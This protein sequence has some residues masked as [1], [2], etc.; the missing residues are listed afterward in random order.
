VGPSALHLPAA[1]V[2]AASDQRT[3]AR[4]RP[5]DRRD[6]HMDGAG[7]LAWPARRLP[8]ASPLAQR[9]S[10]RVLVEL[11]A[12]GPADLPVDGVVVLEHEERAAESES[13]ER[14]LRERRSVCPGEHTFA[15]YVRL[16][17]ATTRTR[18]RCRSGDRVWL[19]KAKLARHPLQ[20][21]LHRGPPR[22]SK[23]DGIPPSSPGRQG[24]RLRA[25]TSLLRWLLRLPSSG[26]P[27]PCGSDG[28]VYSSWR[29]SSSTAASPSRAR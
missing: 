29:S 9:C 23:R 26:S 13:R 20:C 12:L 28:G 4:C 14:A 22:A 17:T 3:R 27:R 1:T 10:V 19:Y 2:P 18:V 24:L 11:C 16:R 8:G 5:A 7:G 25:R 21:R 6:A 15:P